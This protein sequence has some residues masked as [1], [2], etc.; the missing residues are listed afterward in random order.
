MIYYT[1]ILYSA[2]ISRFYVGYTEN[3]EKRFNEHN[4]GKSKFTRRAKDWKMI[5]FFKFDNKSD[6]ISLEC[7]IKKRGCERFLKSC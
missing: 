2:N 5:K 3:L 4:L 7:T 6:A 1:Y